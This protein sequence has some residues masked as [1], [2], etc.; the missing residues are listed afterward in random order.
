MQIVQSTKEGDLDRCAA[1]FDVSLQVVP[2]VMHPTSRI[3]FVE[4]AKEG[5][6]RSQAVRVESFGREE[7]KIF[8]HSVAKL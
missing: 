6:E 5:E 1:A 2:L 7:I 3:S 4:I 8:G